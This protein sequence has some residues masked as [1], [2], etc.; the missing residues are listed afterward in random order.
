MNADMNVLVTAI[1]KGRQQLQDYKAAADK[2]QAQIDESDLGSQLRFVKELQASTSDS[3]AALESKL[4]TLALAEYDGENKQVHPAVMVKKFKVID[5]A[6]EAMKL[7]AMEHNHPG[8]LSLNKTAANQV[9]TGPTA[10][11]FVVISFE[12]RAQIKSDLSEYL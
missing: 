6:P 3:L 5:Y 8:L 4:K 11:A 7:W 2:V 1:A 10:P 12:D 9:A